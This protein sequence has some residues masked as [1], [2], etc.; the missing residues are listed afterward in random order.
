MTRNPALLAGL[1]IVA[2]C[3]PSAAQDRIAAGGVSLTIPPMLHEVQDA[4]GFTFA[5][6]GWRIAWAEA[7]AGPGR[8]LLAVEGF[9]GSGDGRLL[10]GGVRVGESRDPVSVGNCLTF[11]LTDGNAHPL[12]D[13]TI[14]GIV[15]TATAQSDAGMS[16]RLTTTSYRAVTQGRCLAIDRFTYASPRAIPEGAPNPEDIESALDEAVASIRIR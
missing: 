13:R 3:A 11:G 1:V 12:P 6:G 15:F 7:D 16:Q 8:P 14:G 10:Q 9:S 5:A 2:A 4:E